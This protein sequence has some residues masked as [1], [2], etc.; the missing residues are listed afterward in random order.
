MISFLLFLANPSLP[1]NAP[2]GYQ[3]CLRIVDIDH[4]DHNAPVIVSLAAAVE[5]CSEER[6]KELQF[7]I[8]KYRKIWTE[9]SHE[10]IHLKAEQEVSELELKIMSRWVSSIFEEPAHNHHILNIIELDKNAKN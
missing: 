10:E 7:R 3:S 8:E 6:T 2:E 5:A 9:R 4:L 1:E